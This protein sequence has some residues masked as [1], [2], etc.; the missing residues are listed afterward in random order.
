VKHFASARFWRAYQ[1]LPK[2]VRELA[3]AKYALLKSDPEHPSLRFKRIGAYWSVRVGLHFRALAIEAASDLIWF[4]IG[5]HAD[6]DALLGR[7]PAAKSKRAAR[8]SK[9]R[10]SR[11][12]ASTRQR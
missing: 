8:T 1:A 12:R 9:P 10:N 3:D 6:Y 11:R 4:W 5:S 7:K 2:E